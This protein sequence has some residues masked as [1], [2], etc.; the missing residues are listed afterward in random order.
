MCLQIILRDPRKNGINTLLSLVSLSLNGNFQTFLDTP[1]LSRN[2]LY[3]IKC[4]DLF[5]ECGSEGK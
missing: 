1:F 3:C 5:V 2:G 4:V